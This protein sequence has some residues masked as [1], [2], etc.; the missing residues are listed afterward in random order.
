MTVL[1]RTPQAVRRSQSAAE[2]FEHYQA[3][4]DPELLQVLVERYLPL[5]KHLARGYSTGADRED[6]EQVAAVGL[7][8]AARRFDPSRGIA[9]T[10]FAVPTISGEI[11]RYFRDHGWAVRVPRQ[12]QEL[13]ARVTRATEQLTLE[14]GRSP[15]PEEIAARCEEGVERVLEA[16]IAHQAHWADSLDRTRDE[17]DDDNR[18]AIAIGLEE[19]G[20]TRAEQAADVSRLMR[21]LT[22]RERQVLHLRFT[23]DLIQQDI[24]ARLGMSQMQVSRTITAAINKLQREQQ[25]EVE[26]A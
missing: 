17:D 25:V 10:S 12:L 4:H 18:Q 11:K 3:G 16:R 6:V 22:P 9:F 20:F 13:S 21:Q 1:S 7:I 2:L 24:A 19:P 14:L 23:E 8:K 5:A 15:T 26:S